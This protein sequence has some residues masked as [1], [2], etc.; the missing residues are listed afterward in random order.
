MIASVPMQVYGENTRGAGGDAEMGEGGNILDRGQG[1][2]D[3]GI[4]SRQGW[5]GKVK[6]GWEE[7][8]CTGTTTENSTMYQKLLNRYRV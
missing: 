3:G 8:S 2:G 5:G 1:D 7:D 4:G 6:G